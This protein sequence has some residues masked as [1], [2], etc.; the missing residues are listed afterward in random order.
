MIAKFNFLNNLYKMVSSNYPL[1]IYRVR[2][3]NILK[4]FLP[5]K[6]FQDY[7]GT[8]RV[9]RNSIVVWHVGMGTEQEL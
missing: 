5:K 3:V 6:V 9:M 1:K 4:Y 7:G 8:G 2:F